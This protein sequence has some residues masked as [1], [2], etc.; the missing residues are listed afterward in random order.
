MSVEVA[1]AETFSVP[2]TVTT[3]EPTATIESTTTVISASAIE[4]MKPWASAYKDAAFK[5]VRP[6]ITVRSTGIRRVTVIAILA[7]RRWPHIGRSSI[8]WPNTYSHPHLRV[9]TTRND[10]AKPKQ[11]RIF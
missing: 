3:V 2:A 10:H 7:N 11:N 8:D 1:A 4:T 5:V 6:V 9:R